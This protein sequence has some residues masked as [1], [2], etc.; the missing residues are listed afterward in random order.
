MNMCPE[1]VYAQPL[2]EVFLPYD[3]A[4]PG[5]NTV[6]SVCLSVIQNYGKERRGTR[7]YALAAS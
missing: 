3:I 6:L 4:Q 7:T 2:L 5:L 1:L